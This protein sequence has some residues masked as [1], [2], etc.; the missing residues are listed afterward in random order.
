MH[1]LFHARRNENLIEYQRNKLE[2]YD[3][4]LIIP[5]IPQFMILDL[6]DLALL[7]TIFV[8]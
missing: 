5:S 2:R 1:V 6:D 7:G 8:A 4:M 3:T